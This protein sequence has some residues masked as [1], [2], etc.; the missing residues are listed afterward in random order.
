MTEGISKKTT[1]SSFISPQKTPNCRPTKSTLKGGSRTADPPAQ[2]ISI[3]GESAPDFSPAQDPPPAL[4]IPDKQHVTGDWGR[5]QGC[6]RKEGT[7]EAVRQAVGGV[8]KAVRGGYC[9][10]QMPLK[11]AL[12]VREAVAGHRLGAL[13]GGGVPPPLPMHS[14]PWTTR[15]YLSRVVTLLEY[16]SRLL[17]NCA[18]LA[19]LA[20]ASSSAF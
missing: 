4:L 18:I 19:L 14:W 10:L 3:R 17:C 16:C 6:N 11:L 9:R 15:A 2:A 7:S 5:G 1:S 12:A 13:E 20:E 8:A